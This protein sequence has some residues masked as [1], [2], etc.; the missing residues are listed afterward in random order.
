VELLFYY[1]AWLVELLFF[2]YYAWLVELLFYYYVWLVELLFYY[3][4]AWL[5]EL[6]FSIPRPGTGRS[7]G[8]NSTRSGS[9]SICM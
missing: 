6:L 3:Y 1:Y 7:G 8:N 5:V 2:Y 4:Y 9:S